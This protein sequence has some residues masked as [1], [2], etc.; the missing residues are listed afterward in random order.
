[1][2]P[3]P[4][5]AN[6]EGGPIIRGFSLTT[7]IFLLDM[8]LPQ[9]DAYH[10]GRQLQH[11]QPWVSVALMQQQS[12]GQPA[13]QFYVT[14]QYE[15]YAG[16]HVLQLHTDCAPLLL[17]CDPATIPLVS[18][19]DLCEAG[20]LGSMESNVVAG[21]ALLSCLHLPN[22][23]RRCAVFLVLEKVIQGTGN[24]DAAHRAY[25][26]IAPKSMELALLSQLL[27]ARSVAGSLGS[28]PN[29]QCILTLLLAN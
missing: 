12:S 11:L 18:P 17:F 14:Y 7:L 3:I 1:M 20:N 16:F 15:A 23:Q 13:Q 6:A 19:W 28:I 4:G 5:E 2:V 25:R 9:L 10:S 27:H 29:T 8:V 24:K 22:G 26:R 21:W